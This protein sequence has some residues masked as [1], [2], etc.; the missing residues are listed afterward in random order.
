ML[1]QVPPVVKIN[2]KSLNILWSFRPAVV[3]CSNL[4]NKISPCWPIVWKS[5]ECS[6]LN[7]FCASEASLY[8]KAPPSPWATF[9]L[10]IVYD[11][12]KDAVRTVQ[13]TERYSSLVKSV[14]STRV[15]SQTPE[16]LQAEDDQMYGPVVKAQTPT[17]AK[18]R[19][20]KVLHPFL[21]CQEPIET[22]EPESGP[23]ARI[24]LNRGQGRSLVPSVTRIL[25]Q[26]LSPDQIF[27]LER[28]RKKMIAELGEEG[29]KE[30]SQSKIWKTWVILVWMWW[31]QM[32]KWLCLFVV[33]KN[34]FI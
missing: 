29:F 25:Q 24:L 7:E 11:R 9:L 3:A 28:W 26:T 13:W 5:P 18:T 19:V 8:L 33:L 27:Y 31:D 30:Y 21:D 22:E 10:I 16:T 14:M 4:A 15:S 23:P 1:G 17:I 6:L 32:K 12:Q 34:R 2:T 20:P